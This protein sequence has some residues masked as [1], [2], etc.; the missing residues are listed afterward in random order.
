MDARGRYTIYIFDAEGSGPS[1][2]SQ[3]GAN[4]PRL[5]EALLEQEADFEEMLDHATSSRDRNPGDTSRVEEHTG[6][7]QTS[8]QSEVLPDGELQTTGEGTTGM[9]EDAQKQSVQ[10]ILHEGDSVGTPSESRTSESQ[11]EQTDGSEDPGERSSTDLPEMDGIVQEESEDRSGTHREVH[12]G[13]R[14]EF[15]RFG[16][17]VVPTTGTG[18]EQPVDGTVGH[19][20]GT[21]GEDN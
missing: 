16:Y 9:A 10:P 19:T 6:R 12:Q 2:Y 13:S 11:Q 14:V 15:D 1:R 21:S 4:D 8:L 17:Q 18:S 20:S 3:V 5:L 7:E